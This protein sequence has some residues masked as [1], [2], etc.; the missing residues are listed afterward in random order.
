VKSL[1]AVDLAPV[2]YTAE[3]PAAGM[4]REYDAQA[5]SIIDGHGLLIPDDQPRSDTSL[6]EHPP[7][8]SIHLSAI[9][10]LLGRNYFVV[11][12]IQN[13][14]NSFSPVLLFLIAGTLF[15]WRTGLASGVFAAVW[16]HLSYDSNLILPDSLCALPILLAVYCLVKAQRRGSKSWGPYVF[17]G[18]LLGISVWYRPNALLMPEFLGI[19]LTIASTRFWRVARRGAVMALCSLFAIAP[20]TIRNYMI[21]RE[22]VPVQI[23][24]GLNLWTGIGQAGGGRFGAVSY[25]KAAAEQDAA[26]YGDARYAASWYTPDGIARDH[27]RLKRS[28]G[29]ITHHPIWYAG[30]VLKRMGH[31]FNYTAEAALVFKASDTRLI[32]AG[33]KERQIIEG[34]IARGKALDSVERD[35]VSP[36]AT[37]ALGQAISWMR[38]AVRGLQRIAKETS[39]V[40]MLLGAFLAFCLSARRTFLILIVPLYYLLIQSPIHTEFR[41]TLPMH[42]CLFVLAA[43]A[44][45]AIVSVLAKAMES[46]LAARKPASTPMSRPAHALA[47]LDVVGPDGNKK[48]ATDSSA[49]PEGA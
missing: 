27:E 32:E 24:T 15:G 18:L 6:L 16:H 31:M 42:Y 41:Y 33:R 44:W 7:G 40:F 25:D 49:R 10:K 36:G 17:A 12:L 48:L 26:L 21:Y 13:V 19:A 2:M 20:I 11:Q 37:L 28:V 47:Y 14:I 1:Y 34:K 23:G 22:F 29:V 38:P 4:A 35:G 8:Y 9:Y 39:L 46:R 3:Q 30:S 43:M 45:V 5:L